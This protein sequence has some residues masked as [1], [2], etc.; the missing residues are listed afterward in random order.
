MWIPLKRVPYAYRLNWIDPNRK[1]LRSQIVLPAKFHPSSGAKPYHVASSYIPFLVANTLKICNWKNF[2]VFINFGNYYS[3]L[4]KCSFFAVF[5]GITGV[6]RLS[7][8]VPLEITFSWVACSFSKV[9]FPIKISLLAIEQAR[10]S[11]RF[12]SW[13]RKLQVQNS[14]QIKDLKPLTCRRLTFSFFP[15]IFL[16]APWFTDSF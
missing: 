10:S 13:N 7:S 4:K 2:L 5:I 15:S 9:V 6:H 14:A 16:A 3:S 11:I 12:R 1:K 8:A